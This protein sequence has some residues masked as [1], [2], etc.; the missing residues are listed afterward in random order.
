MF[1]ANT[2]ADNEGFLVGKKPAG[3]PGAKTDENY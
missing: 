3:D 2:L 1:F